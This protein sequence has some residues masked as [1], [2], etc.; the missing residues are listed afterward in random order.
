ME[1]VTIFRRGLLH[2]GWPLMA[3]QIRA[4]DSADGVPR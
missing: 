1:A 3:W 4:T 2:V